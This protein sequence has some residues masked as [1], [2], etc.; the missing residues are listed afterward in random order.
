MLIDEARIAEIRMRFESLRLVLDERQLR[1]WAAA[2]AK[3][4]GRGGVA[5][6]TKATGI[7]GK[8][9]WMGMR[10]LSEMQGGES[11]QRT[12]RER[13]RR[14]GAGRKTVTAKD[15]T[16]LDDLESLV[17]PAT[18]GDPESPLRWT[19]KSTA[20]LAEELRDRGHQVSETTVRRLLKEELEYS[21]QANAKTREGAEHPDRNAQFEYISDQTIAF[22]DAGQPVISVDTKKKELVG[23]FKNGGREWQ[24]KGEPE[25]VRVHDF[26]DPTLGKVIP[27]GVYDFGRDEGWVSV[28]VDHDTAEFA[29]A[30]IKQW[31]TTMGKKA[32]PEAQ[33]LL[34]TADSGGSNAARS[35][36][37]KRTVQDIANRTGLEITVCHF[38]P[39]TS[40]WNKIE[41][42]MFSHIS[43]NWRGRPLVDHATIVS[44]IA[45]TRTKTGLKVRARLD[46]RSYPLGIKVTDAEIAELCIRSHR[47]HGDWNYTVDAQH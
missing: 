13:I 32:Y 16:L 39:G 11:M 17:S 5:A 3:A 18:R 43:Q 9:I 36:L 20:T 40:K 14:P 30:A 31:W 34:I 7:R 42:R 2:E 24:P 10:E 19:A 27:Y 21:L 26:A 37:W 23:D 8:R 6:V 45:S 47:F 29:G 12:R 28:G 38:P 33:Q 1:L 35:R 4:L 46:T 41:H 44:L 25:R 22:L 15:D